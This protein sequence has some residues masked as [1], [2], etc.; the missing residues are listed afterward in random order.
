[1]GLMKAA[2]GA[3][4]GVMAD[5]W[6]EYFYCE[7]LPT[8]ILAVKGKKKVT[9]RSS[10]YKGDEN[11]ITTGSLIAVA[12]GQ[13]M[14]IVEQGKVVEVC[15]EPGEFVYDA[16]TEPSVFAGSLGESI[17]QV[18]RNIG[19]RFTFGG[20][21]PKDQR[22]Y[23]FNTKE[24]PGNKYGTASPVPFR[25][26]DARA[27]I[28]MDIGIKCFGEYSI[29]LK[30]PLLFYTNVCGNVSEDY[31]VEQ[32]AGQMRTELL[33][34][35]QPAFARISGMGIR[36]SALPGHTM[37]LADALNEQLSSKWRDLRGMEIV[38]FGV[39]SVKAD[40]EDEKTIKELQRNAAFTD[41][42]RAAA[43]LV[44]AQG[45]AMKMAASNTAAGPAMAF[46]GMGMAGQAGGVNAQ[47]LFQ[48]GQQQQQM[49]QQPAPAPAAGAWKCTC[50][51]ENTGKFCMECG[52]PKPEEAWKCPQCGTENRGKFCSE[53]GARKPAGVYQCSK[54]GWKPEDP[55]HPPK[56]CPECGDPFN[57]AD[58][59]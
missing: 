18:F 49:Q 31:K 1:M 26:V 24:V 58:L 5:Q 20:E 41:P 8:D 30:N 11:I 23:Y 14:L 57:E 47:N 13:C 54:C 10:N 33:T 40:E 9:G 16:S 32:L 36:Y 38:S 44:G 22:V 7:A 48:M 43:H 29:R 17:G 51:A 4:G 42:T 28:D 39:S 52:K 15:A 34:A 56:F 6:K 19:K 27:G 55:A 50:G 2:A 59:K 25:V 3:A 35:L 21:A 46:M 37:E 53:C 45:D 12:D